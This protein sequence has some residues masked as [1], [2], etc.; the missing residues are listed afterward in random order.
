M[1]CYIHY[2]DTTLPFTLL[3][4][5]SEHQLNKC[6]ISDLIQL[7]LTKYRERHPSVNIELNPKK[8]SISASSRKSVLF[9][10]SELVWK[11]VRNKD[12]LNIFL[13]TSVLFTSQHNFSVM[14]ASQPSSERS[15]LLLSHAEKYHAEQNYQKAVQ[16]Y[17]NLLRDDSSNR[18]AILGLVDIYL[19]VGR[20]IDALHH[21]KEGIHHHRDDLVFMLKLGQSYLGCGDGAKAVDY[22]MRYSKELRKNGKVSSTEKYQLQVA[23]CQAY[24]LLNQ[25]DMAIVVIEG[26]VRETK[27]FIPAVIEYSKL[28][29]DLDVEQATPS[30]S[31][32]CQATFDNSVAY[33]EDELQLLAAWCTLVKVLYLQG[34][35]PT[36][37]AL[38]A[39][40]NPLVRDR[41]LHKTNI[42][43]EIAYFECIQK[44]M[45]T[46]PLPCLTE[47]STF[48]YFIGD[49]HCISPA[50]R[51]LRC[52]NSNFVFHPILSTGTKIW[53][54]R[55]QS[56][57][58]PKENFF[59]SVEKI[60]LEA[61][62]VI[63]LGEIDCREALLRC[64]E[65]SI[66]DS[67]EEAIERLLDV[68][69][70]VMEDLISKYKWKLFIHPVPPV[71]DLSRPVVRQFNQQLRARLHLRS[72][73]CYLN[74]EGDLLDVEGKLKPELCFDD[75]HLH[76][77]YV[78][79]LEKCLNEKLV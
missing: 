61:N 73:C 53:H 9:P 11:K 48:I 19:E 17:K 8:W 3:V 25:K 52:K 23:L 54:L 40:L 14:P 76:P 29:F 15:N 21:V 2:E 75:T 30:P 45:L 24:Q 63:C 58:Y 38:I 65:K 35:H 69:L 72:D 10:H 51:T 22:L 59:N 78:K 36:T 56:C 28:T 39:L 68:Y 20:Y 33:S 31:P 64:V 71:L 77:K 16:V 18:G 60:P 66:Y 32:P 62:V 12:D 37:S 1:R 4:T 41:Q 70:S 50:W 27:E 42:R 13:S 5:L 67:L 49:S 7:F 44:A 46:S 6:T 34:A 74:M 55:P 79:I 43:N 57:F 26:V 47:N